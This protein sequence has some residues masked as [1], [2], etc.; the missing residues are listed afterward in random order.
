MNKKIIVFLMILTIVSSM[1]YAFN[2][3][4][5]FTKT[6]KEAVQNDRDSFKE[7]TTKS[8]S[9]EKTENTNREV[10]KE[11]SKRIIDND[12]DNKEQSATSRN[13]EYLVETYS[14]LG[15]SNPEKYVSEVG[16][17]YANENLYMFPEAEYSNEE[18][19]DY[20]YEIPMSFSGHFII[21][22]IKLLDF[23]FL[24]NE[25]G[26]REYRI[27]FML[28]SD[29]GFYDN[30]VMDNN[31]FDESNQIPTSPM[32]S[33]SVYF[34]DREE[35]MMLYN[36]VIE[37]LKSYQ[38]N[39]DLEIDPEDTKIKFSTKNKPSVSEYEDFNG[40]LKTTASAWVYLTKDSYDTI[41]YV[42]DPE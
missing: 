17:L 19:T 6:N 16:E 9:R 15:M 18:D 23:Q 13:T 34:D 21:P 28:Q 27:H 41:M 2:L 24:R 22:K 8:N 20:N 10:S 11:T 38:G 40:K 30:R 5:I 3:R 36:Y 33:F 32:N 35:A 4:D 37:S 31:Y 25:E 29:G 12:D 7:A 39:S 42:V 14:K 1:V 26:K